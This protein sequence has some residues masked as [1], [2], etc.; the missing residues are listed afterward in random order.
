MRS[1]FPLLA[2]MSGAL[3]ISRVIAD[4]ARSDELLRICR[5]TVLERGPAG[6]TPP[7]GT[8]DIDRR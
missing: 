3:S 7:T 6:L 1:P 8:G 4:P 2:E 5:E